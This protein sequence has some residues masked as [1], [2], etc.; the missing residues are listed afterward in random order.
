MPAVY[1]TRIHVRV[2][3]TRNA[4]PADLTTALRLATGVFA[5]AD[6]GVVW[7]LCDQM[8]P[9]GARACDTPIADDELAVRLVRVRGKPSARGELSLG[10]SLIDTSSVMGTLA[11]VYLNRVEWLA[12][13]ARYDG[14]RL[15][16]FA[17]A[18][19]LGHLLLGTNAHSP[20]G[21]M[22]ALW[23]RI[24][25]QRNDAADWLFTSAEKAAM[26]RAVRRRQSQTAAHVTWSH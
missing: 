7:Q 5:A 22:R 16:G 26:E 9:S 14:T 1:E 20:T 10:Y 21:L 17:L 19:E 15:L 8:G 13:Q 2:Y 6:I 3:E 4:R 12:S 11:T 23:S 18:H 24:E 25:L